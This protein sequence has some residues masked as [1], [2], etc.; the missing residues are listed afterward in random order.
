M[1]YG[2][3]DV[4]LLRRKQG[5]LYFQYS[6]AI[7]GAAILYMRLSSQIWCGQPHMAS[8]LV[9]VLNSRKIMLSTIK[10]APSK[11][12]CGFKPKRGSW[13]ATNGMF[14]YHFQKSETASQVSCEASVIR[15][16]WCNQ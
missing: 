4:Q 1:N 9:C 10:L 5:I 16:K 2:I 8:N 14:V 11:L 12:L 15:N 7:Q 3:T 6:A 13:L